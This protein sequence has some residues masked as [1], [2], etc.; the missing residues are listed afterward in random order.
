MGMLRGYIS[1][2]LKVLAHILD[3]TP[4]TYFCLKYRI[5]LASAAMAEDAKTG[6]LK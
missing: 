1:S 6:S 2:L 5:P 3:L 4:W